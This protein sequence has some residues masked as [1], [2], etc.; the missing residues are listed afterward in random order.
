MELSKHICEKCSM[1]GIYL[2]ADNEGI[3]RYYCE[4]HAPEGSMK[5]GETPKQETGF[6]KFLPL[7]IIF[8]SIILFTIVA[9]S[10]HGFSLEFAM[11]MMMGSF[12]A[13]FGMFKV[14][15]LKAF[16]DA[17][18]TYDIIAIRSRVYAFTYPFLELL[19]A[20]LYL[21]NTGGVYRD[22]FT[23][24]V[25][26]VSS[27]GVIQKLRQK[28]EIPCACLGMVFKIPMTSVT[29]IEDVL[30]AL[31]ALAMVVLILVK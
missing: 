12:F 16:A 30:M 28:E 8:S 14:F 26:T 21:S 22:I 2:K 17:Y 18:S 24:V 27:I 7:I 29:L 6:R 5:I 25:M 19:L 13:I 1:E 4:H 3:V 10:L 15:N 31:E 11:R 23:F 9:T 20:L